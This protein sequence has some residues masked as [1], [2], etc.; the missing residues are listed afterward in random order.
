[1][2][3][4]PELT[5]TKKAVFFLL[6]IVVITFYVYFQPQNLPQPVP[7]PQPVQ[8]VIVQAA[9]EDPGPQENFR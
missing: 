8:P 7:I 3:V 6:N 1:M 9:R 2:P 5:L 4:F